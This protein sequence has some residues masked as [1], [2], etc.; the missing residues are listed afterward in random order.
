MGLFDRFRKPENRNLENP[1]AP[2]S[3]N[4]FLQVMGWG[5][6]YASSGVT[7]NVDTALGVPGIVAG[8]GPGPERCGWTLTVRRSGTTEQQGQIRLPTAAS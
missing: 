3:A 5:D 7:V 6:L 4:D 8:E 1:K 2:V